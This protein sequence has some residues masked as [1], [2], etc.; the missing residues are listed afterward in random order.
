MSNMLQEYNRAVY[1]LINLLVTEHPAGRLEPLIKI[2]RLCFNVEI[3][4]FKEQTLSSQPQESVIQ[5]G[6]LKGLST[7]Y[8][9]STGAIND[10]YSEYSVL[11]QLLDDLS[12]YTEDTQAGIRTFAGC[13]DTLDGY[14]VKVGECL[15]EF[16]DKFS[17]TI[18]KDPEFMLGGPAAMEYVITSLIMYWVYCM[19]KTPDLHPMV[20]QCT[21]RLGLSRILD[22]CRILVSRRE[23]HAAKQNLWKIMKE[24]RA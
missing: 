10:L 2:L 1:W 8:L 14:A 19:C 6:V 4:C 22:P 9:I 21:D 13:S 12:D 16:I 15:A 5:L 3:R 11:I 7:G 18:T 17:D 24:F 23:K 20:R